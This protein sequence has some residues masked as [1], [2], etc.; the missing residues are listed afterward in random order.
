MSS[1]SPHPARPPPPSR[2]S[3]KHGHPRTQVGASPSPWAQGEAGRAAS[4]SRAQGGAGAGG[5][6]C[7][8]SPCSCPQG[9]SP[10]VGLQLSSSLAPN[11]GTWPLSSRPRAVPGWGSSEPAPSLDLR[12]SHPH[13][14]EGPHPATPA[15]SGSWC[16][17]QSWPLGPRPPRSCVQPCRPPCPPDQGQVRGT[18]SSVP[19]LTPAWWGGG[20][21]G[22]WPPPQWPSVSLTSSRTD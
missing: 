16:P 6:P 5:C 2:P 10:G 13:S 22:L 18:P 8:A 20:L 4:F 9:S 19:M 7:P 14:R 1:V 15:A 21:C 3:G 12:P 11:P 17:D